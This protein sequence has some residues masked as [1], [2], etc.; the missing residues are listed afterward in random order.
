MPCRASA[1]SMPASRPRIT[2][3][4]GDAAIGVRLRIEEDLG[5]DDVVGRRPVEIGGGEVAE[6][7]LGPKHVGAAIIDVEE[8]LQ[9]REL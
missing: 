1:S 8:V 6:I 9:V 2:V 4:N 3:S 7:P 5:V